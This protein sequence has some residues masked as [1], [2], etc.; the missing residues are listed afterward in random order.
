MSRS[1]QP[2]DPL[3]GY[4]PYDPA[5]PHP[6][7]AEMP[8]AERQAQGFNVGDRDGML[9]VKAARLVRQRYGLRTPFDWG[10]RAEFYDKR[11]MQ[12]FRNLQRGTDPWSRHV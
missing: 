2:H 6:V 4:E 9:M 7:A 8:P 1:R 5:E 10:Q 12:V 3:R 11:A